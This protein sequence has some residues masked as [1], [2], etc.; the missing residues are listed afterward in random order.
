MKKERL[1]IAATLMLFTIAARAADVDD[2]MKEKLEAAKAAHQVKLDKLN[3]I[4]IDAMQKRED[5][6]RKRKL[7]KIVDETKVER[8]AFLK[9]GAVPA[10]LNATQHYANLK[11][12]RAEL[13][14]VYDATIKAYAS[15]PAKDEVRAVITKERD[16]LVGEQ[17]DPKAGPFR[18]GSVWKGAY[19]INARPSE[20]ITFEVTFLGETGFDATLSTKDGSEVIEMKGTLNRGKIDW[21]AV[22]VLKGSGTI[23]G[24]E[25]TA[26]MRGNAIAGAVSKLGKKD[27]LNTW[28]I[29]LKLA[30]KG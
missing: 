20:E 12:I 30:P 25:G 24:A 17:P 28:N 16:E 23:A 27:N 21:K 11:L 5:E 4:I 7:P 22:K 18:A 26:I 19:Q 9:R 3:N 14:A 2:P 10:W 1:A 8:E 15:D 6:A 29:V 13:L